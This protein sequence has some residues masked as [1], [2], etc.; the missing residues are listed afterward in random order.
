[1]GSGYRALAWAT[2]LLGSALAVLGVGLYEGFLPASL[3]G[4]LTYDE[5]GIFAALAYVVAIC[6]YL[7]EGA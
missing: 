4:N 6:A 1:M 7:K 5:L 2:A 3:V